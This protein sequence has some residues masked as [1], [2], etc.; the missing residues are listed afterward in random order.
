MG[1]D[2]THSLAVLDALVPQPGWETEL[3]LFSSYSV[4]LVAVAAI[5]EALAGEGDDHEK[6][7]RPGLARACERMRD[8]FRVIC[9]AGRIAVPRTGQS[10]LVVADRWIREVRHDGNE[11]SWHAK[12]AL[13]K[14]RRIDAPGRDIEWRLWVGSRNLTRDT[15]WDSALLALGTKSNSPNSVDIAIARAGEV[16]A[17]K[18]E[19]S[20]WSP[21]KVAAE[22]SQLHWSWPRDLLEVVSFAMWPD[23]QPAMRFPDPPSGLQRFIALS[24]FVNASI[25]KR[26]AGWQT[27][28]KRQ[29]LTIP[30]TLSNLAAASDSPLSEFTSLHRLEMPVEVEEA[31]FEQID[32]SEDEPDEVHRGLHAKLIWTRSDSGDELWLGSANLTERAW[33]GRN[34]EVMVHAKLEPSVGDELLHGLVEGLATEVS[35]AELTPDSPAE[36]EI[37]QSLDNIRNR[38]A[39]CWDAR[40]ERVKED[41]YLLCKSAVAPLREVDDATL[42]VRLLGQ[43]SWVPWGPNVTA[44]V[45]PEPSVHWQTELV[46]MRISSTVDSASRVTWIARAVIYPP[47]ELSRD[48]AV[49]ARMMGPRAFLVWLRTLLGEISGETDED[50]WPSRNNR[51][52]ARRSVSK[53]DGSIKIWSSPS[54]ENILKAH[55]RNR[56]SAL[57]EVDRALDIWA[58]EIRNGYAA[59][60]D[61]ED[62]SA[63]EELDHFQD[64]WQVI[65]KGLQT[66][67]AR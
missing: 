49:L 64:V 32:G 14:Y 12:I 36:D 60:A 34:T 66:G 2:T 25:A 11:R 41:D 37:A 55:G 50:S 51:A 19:L 65:R 40:L 48:R 9:Q 53:V 56:S 18:A 3:A 57:Q 58:V 61:P 54:L 21:K 22:L 27:T 6:M 29:L 16:L 30:S 62:L 7:K 31:H 5:V 13:V 15:S 44:V 24:P 38:I 8:R 63:L 67:N 59:D 26:L 39:A 1:L 45:L 4:D 47:F 42:S 52:A 23:A 20:G 10:A 33:D 28:G 17:T 43:T 35:F 46:E